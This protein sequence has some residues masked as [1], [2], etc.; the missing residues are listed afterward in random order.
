M[1]IFNAI[2]QAIAQG[3]TEFLPVSSSGHLSVIQYFIGGDNSGGVVFA[4]ILHIGTL[5]AVLIAFHKLIFRLI[6]EFGKMVGQICTGK[7]KWK[8]RTQEQ[9][10]VIMLLI[11]TALLVPIYFTLGDWIEHFAEDKSILLEGICFII[12]GVIL[13]LADRCVKGKKNIGDI[14][15]KNALAV[16]A[17]QCAALF[18]GISRSGSTI[19]GGLLSG[20]TREVAVQYSFILGIPAILGGAVSEIGGA[21]KEE[22]ASIGVLPIIIGLIVSFIVGVAS[23]YMV[24]LIVKKEKF[25]FFSIYLFALGLF[26]IIMSFVGGKGVSPV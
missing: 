4:L 5:G 17:F 23:I 10:M 22:L 24:R 15:T 21:T 26:C 2:F 1:S 20:M 11:S 14:N 13:I 18:P 25:T 8:S 7:F 3:L 16:G 19:T 12:T 9:N 6:I